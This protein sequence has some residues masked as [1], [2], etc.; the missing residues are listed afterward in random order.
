MHALL[1]QGA[2]LKNVAFVSL[3]QR[4]KFYLQVLIE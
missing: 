3:E 4:L 1:T 2:P